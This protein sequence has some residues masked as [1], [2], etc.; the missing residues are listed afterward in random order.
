MTLQ[1]IQVGVVCHTASLWTPCQAERVLTAHDEAPSTPRQFVEKPR[2][3]S[4]WGDKPRRPPK[5]QD[6]EAV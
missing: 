6:A 2:G 1:E 5:N 4:R 3:L